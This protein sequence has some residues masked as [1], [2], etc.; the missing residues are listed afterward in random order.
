MKFVPT[1]LKCYS[2]RAT[3][4][5]LI[6]EKGISHVPERLMPF[7]TTAAFAKAQDQRCQKRGGSIGRLIIASLQSLIALPV[8]ATRSRWEFI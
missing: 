6:G 3:S 5:A 8:H 4:L 7:A 1:A 2:P